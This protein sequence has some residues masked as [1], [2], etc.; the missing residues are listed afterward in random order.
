MHRATLLQTAHAIQRPLW[1]AQI[2]GSGKNENARTP[3]PVPTLLMVLEE[4]CSTTSE[5]CCPPA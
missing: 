3:D 2:S 5:T 1:I 4:L